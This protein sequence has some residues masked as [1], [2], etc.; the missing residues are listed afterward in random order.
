M[1]AMLIIKFQLNKLYLVSKTCRSNKITSHQELSAKIILDSQQQANN[2][3]KAQDL[4]KKTKLQTIQDRANKLQI[5]HKSNGKP[6][7]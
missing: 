5:M 4:H 3:S 2:K 7:K 6:N 1:L